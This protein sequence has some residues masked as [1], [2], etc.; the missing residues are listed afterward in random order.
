[1]KRREFSFSLLG[2]GL[3]ASQAEAQSIDLPTTLPNGIAAGDVSQTG[4]V[5]WTRSTVPG[6]VTFQWSLVQDFTTLVG[7]VTRRQTIT[8]KPFK[9][10]LQGLSANTTYYYRVANEAGASL[11]GQFRTLA[12]NGFN[13]LRFG[14]TG[15]WRGELSPYPA[16]KNVPG[17]NLAFLIE[18]GD[19]IYADFPSPALNVPQ[20][21][22]LSEF[23]TKHAEVYSTRFGQNYWADLRQTTPI[24]AMI[25]DHEVTNDFAGGATPS[26][27]ARFANYTGTYINET[28]LF[29]NGL[30][31]FVDY[32]PVRAEYY[33]ATGDPRTANKRKL[34]RYRTFGQD[35]AVFLLDTRSFRDQGLASVANP[36]NATQVGT[37]LANSLGATNRTL[38]G[39]QQL[40]DL[41]ADLLDA[42]A[43]GITWKFILVPEPI[44]NLGVVGAPD[45]FEGY[46]A[47]RSNILKFLVDNNIL[48][49][50][51][52]SA[53]V[54]G[55]ATNNLNYQVFTG[56]PTNPIAQ[57]PVPGAFEITT[58]SVAFDAPF[59]PTVVSLAQAA[60]LLTSPQAAFYNAQN[61]V[62]K[63]EFVRALI[64]QLITP[65]G[66]P[67]LGLGGIANIAITAGTNDISL[68]TYGW[69]EFE[70]NAN[71]QALTVTTYGID[72]YSLSELNAQTA[73]G[74]TPTGII[75]RTP[76][77]VS[78]FVVTP[79][80]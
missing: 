36:S 35:A 50:V 30:E 45:R 20:A 9:N 18:H 34:Y 53:D 64:N 17:R 74:S 72:Y 23:R 70:I 7:S 61:R 21:Q 13:G 47:E 10:I 77:V 25:D 65:L 42:K 79:L 55:T 28:A 62:G 46:A 40:A 8:E 27:D 29:N 12:T 71:T 16:I 37:F 54:H 60:G 78:Q 5:L 41:K 75:N 66:Y 6:R 43:K 4:A 3:L 14:V 11:S 68:H 69:T 73:N 2:L 44:Q 63:D 39:A 15:D 76:V 22:S 49:V 58:G 1:M 56:N 33:G 32:N 51:F 48:N 24:Y 57:V 38:L 80:S 26:S 52:V 59:G 67:S 19:T 31:A